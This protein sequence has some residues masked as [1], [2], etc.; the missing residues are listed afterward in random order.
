MLSVIDE[1]LIGLAW[2]LEEG[3]KWGLTR[4][5]EGEYFGVSAV[6]TNH[7]RALHTTGYTQIA[8]RQMAPWW[9][10]CGVCAH[11]QN[12]PFYF[13]NLTQTN[14]DGFPPISWPSLKYS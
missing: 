5:L 7:I 2:K 9:L 3:V 1:M 8:W 14:T 6:K 4:G 12:G 10:P 13:G 11:A